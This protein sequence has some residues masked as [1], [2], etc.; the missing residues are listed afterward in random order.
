MLTKFLKGWLLI[1]LITMSTIFCGCKENNYNTLGNVV[2]L[3]DSYSTFEGHIPSSY[4]SYYKQGIT[5]NNVTDVKYTWWY[6]VIKRSNSTLLLN[7]SYSGTTICH[8]GYHGYDVKNISFV[9]RF[10]NLKEQNYFE[11]NNV[12]TLIICGGLNDVW[13]GSPLG[14]VKYDNISESDLYALYP[15]FSYL[16]KNAIEQNI[17][18]Y[19]LI[20]ELLSEEVKEKLIEICSHYS[21]PYL[22]LTDISQQGGHPDR[23]GMEKTATDFLNT[24]CK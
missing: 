9:G 5:Y 4:D 2:I 6:K 24:F 1:A 11:Q 22:K 7:D 16:L 18:V 23:E 12:N 17:T 3:G 20:E 13:A 10:N 19:F 14:E 8:T 15:A 21:V